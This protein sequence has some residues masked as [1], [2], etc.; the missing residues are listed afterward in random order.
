VLDPN[1]QPTKLV[2]VVKAADVARLDLFAFVA[3]P[4]VVADWK[5]TIIPHRRSSAVTRRYP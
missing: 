1:G 5:L 2:D 4:S 3:T